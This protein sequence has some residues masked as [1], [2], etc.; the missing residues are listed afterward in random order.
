MPENESVNE[1]T[2]ALAEGEKKA[3]FPLYRFLN[4]ALFKLDRTAAVVGLIIIALYSLHCLVTIG[5]EN[6]DKE[7]VIVLV[8]VASA[9]VAALGV[10]LG[11]KGASK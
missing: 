7:I 11:N 6:L 10:Y 9:V 3:K 5:T 1:E 4:L 2:E 8:G